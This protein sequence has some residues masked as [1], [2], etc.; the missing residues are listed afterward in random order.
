MDCAKCGAQT[1]QDAPS[2][3]I[4]GAATE[5]GAVAAPSSAPS[6]D[7]AAGSTDD[8]VPASFM[9]RFAALFMDKLILAIPLA[10]VV[11]I[12]EWWW[13]LFT[14]VPDR[15]HPLWQ[16]EFPAPCCGG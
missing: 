10:T 6:V 16:V 3:P 4:C 1:I 8:V 11:W 7:F 13:G 15:F 12:V 9:R 5:G 2:C 14:Q